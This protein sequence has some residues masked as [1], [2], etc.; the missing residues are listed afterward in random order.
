MM[1]KIVISVFVL[2]VGLI[3]LNRFTGTPKSIP[4]SHT[5]A[6][7][8]RPIGTLERTVPERRLEHRLPENNTPAQPAAINADL[9]RTGFSAVLLVFSLWVI[10]SGKVDPD[11][12]KWAFGV[13]GSLIGFWLK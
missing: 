3:I 13:I 12:K 10:A 1:K 2:T 4:I 5:M 11:S 7:S 6:A 8:E 9:V